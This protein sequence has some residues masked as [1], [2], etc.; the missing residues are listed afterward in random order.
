[1][2]HSITHRNREE[3]MRKRAFLLMVALSATFAMACGQAEE[4]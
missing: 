4:E 2:H 1:M 3:A